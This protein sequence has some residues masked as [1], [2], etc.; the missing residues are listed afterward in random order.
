[1]EP[2]KKVVV[3]GKEFI[4]KR[5]TFREKGMVYRAA[6]E[7]NPKTGRIMRMDIYKFMLHAILHGVKEPKL[8]VE[9][10]EKMDAAIAEHLFNEIITFNSLPFPK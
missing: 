10:I 6:T 8:T 7:V 9:E 2:E 1:M 3:A 4:I 5:W